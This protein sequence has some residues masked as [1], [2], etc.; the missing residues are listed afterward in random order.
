MRPTLIRT[1]VVVAALAGTVLAATYIIPIEAILLTS[2]VVA[3]IA[4][5]MLIGWFHR[6]APAWWRTPIGR[7][8][9]GIKASIWVLCVGA[10]GRRI[11]EQ[12]TDDDLTLR[13]DSLAHHVLAVAWALTAMAMCARLIVVHRLRAQ[14]PYREDT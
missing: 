6:Y 10:L 4:V 7:T 13:I 3:F 2:C 9:M 12:V 5:S 11:A 14:A 1:A 8:T